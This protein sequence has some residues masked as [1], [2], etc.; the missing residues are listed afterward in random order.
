MPI[1]HK[2]FTKVVTSSSQDEIVNA[3]AAIDQEVNDFLK[4]QHWSQS[5]DSFQ[6]MTVVQETVVVTRTLIYTTEQLV[7]TPQDRPPLS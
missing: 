7:H 4:E 1:K 3:N 5:R 2:T 6:T